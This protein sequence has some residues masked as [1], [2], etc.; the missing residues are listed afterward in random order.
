[1]SYQTEYKRKFDDLKV[2]LEKREHI[3]KDANGGN[4]ILFI[5]PPIDESHYILKAQEVLTGAKFIDVSKILVKF[6]D[7]I[8]IDKVCQRLKDY[9][10]S[11]H[12]IF[13]STDEENGFFDLII[14]EISNAFDNDKFAVLIRTGCLF[15]TGIENSQI[16]ENKLILNSNIPLII[17]YPGQIDH[18]ELKFLN[19]KSASKYRCI[20]IN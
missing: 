16:M 1:M 4:T 6:I 18:G 5:Y 9:Q 3:K 7:R 15:G 20:Q 8:G 10:F 13:A 2:V 12:K 17:F 19:C 11:K 14:K